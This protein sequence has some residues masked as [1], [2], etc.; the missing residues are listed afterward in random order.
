[1]RPILF[2]PA[3]APLLASCSSINGNPDPI[4]RV[5]DN[6]ALLAPYTIDKSLI[7]YAAADN[8]QRNN[9]SRLEYRNFIVA[10][11]LNAIDA[12][13]AWFRTKLSRQKRLGNIGFDLG[14]LA[15]T[16]FGQFAAEA[17]GRRLAAGATALTGV[18]GSIDKQLYF[19]QTLP[20]LLAGMDTERAKVRTRIVQNLKHNEN[21]YP[22]ELAFSDISAYETS[23]TLDRAIENITAK[24]SE[25]RTQAMAELADAIQSCDTTEDLFEPRRRLTTSI[26]SLVGKPD[27][28]AQ[29]TK[30]AERTNSKAVDANGQPLAASEIARNI[31]QSLLKSPC[32]VGALNS[33]IS[34][35]NA[36]LGAQII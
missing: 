14:S 13:Y 30:I 16:G 26:L 35:I 12:Q 22:L 18:R 25:E 33:L 10:L 21:D 7:A 3:F 24:A 8:S 5:S 1:M 6:V 2:L 32:S 17:A 27:G 36:D 4:I 28:V 23:A 11:Y 15:L 31:R 9:M 34:N 20:A 19:D 29:L